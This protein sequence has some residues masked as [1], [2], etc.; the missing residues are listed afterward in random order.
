[1]AE[2]ASGF[3]LLNPNCIIS[4]AIYPVYRVVQAVG[5]HVVADDALAGGDKCVCI[6]E[7]ADFGVVVAGL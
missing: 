3:F 5:E 7:A 2:T 6:D 1:M 4:G